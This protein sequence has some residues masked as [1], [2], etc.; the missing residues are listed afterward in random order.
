MVDSCAAKTTGN[1][2]TNCVNAV[3]SLGIWS[4]DQVPLVLSISTDAAIS[5]VHFTGPSH[6]DWFFNTFAPVLASAAEDPVPGTDNRLWL[7]YRGSTGVYYAWLD[8]S[9]STWQSPSQAGRSEQSDRSLGAGRPAAAFFRGRLHVAA[10][11]NPP[12]SYASCTMPCSQAAHW[13][14]IVEQDWGAQGDMLLESYGSQNGRLN[15]WHRLGGPDPVFTIYSRSK[16]S[17]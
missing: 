6:V 12:I 4:P 14:W 15:L 3:E 10:Q 7:V 9:A 8:G 13:T 16:A 17:Q 5:R 1:D 2:S 11:A